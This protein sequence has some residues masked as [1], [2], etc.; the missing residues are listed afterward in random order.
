MLAFVA[1]VAIWLS[2]RFGREQGSRKPEWTGLLK[3]TDEALFRA[4]ATREQAE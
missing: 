4:Q 3:A 2:Q 1:G